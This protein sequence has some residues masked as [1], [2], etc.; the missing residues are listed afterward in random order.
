[1]DLSAATARL[2]LSPLFGLQAEK[3]TSSP[4]ENSKA[5][6]SP[7]ADVEA[8][9][10]LRAASLDEFDASPSPNSK[11]GAISPASRLSPRSPFTPTSHRYR[12]PLTA[13]SLSPDI[14]A[15]KKYSPSNSQSS[16]VASIT[17]TSSQ[18]VSPN[19]ALLPLSSSS[20]ILGDEHTTLSPS[21]PLVA[22]KY[23]FDA[24]PLAAAYSL[25]PSSSSSPSLPSGVIPSS[26][27][28]NDILQLGHMSHTPLP[29]S[30]L[31]EPSLYHPQRTVRIILR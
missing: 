8:N 23:D 10:A 31:D 28:D 18:P 6:G 25:S 27:H 12:S 5:K 3:S 21:S 29:P 7:F 20:P 4:F 24:A 14:F 2:S 17:G 26:T 16:P 1:M 30:P 22:S 13:E 19:A 11:K 15:A 9:R